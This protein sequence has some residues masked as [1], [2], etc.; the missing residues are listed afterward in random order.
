MALFV[1][2]FGK[3][4]KKK[5]YGVRRRKDSSKYKDQPRR[6]YKWKSKDHLVA[7]CPYNSD[8]D[9]NEKKEKKDK[10]MTFKKKKKGHSYCVTWDS[11]ASSSDDD[12]SDDERKTIKKKALAS[13]AINKPSLF[14][15][16]STCFMAKSNKVQSDD[17]SSDESESEDEEEPSKEEL[18]DMLQEAHSYTNKKRKEFKELRKMHQA[19][20][21][22][23]D[24]LNATHEMIVE[25]H[26]KLEKSHSSLVAQIEKL[27]HYYL[28][29]E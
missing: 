16:P 9:E 12:D 22:S 7:K 17:E 25:A 28:T 6:C 21:Q 3:F 11:D 26:E 18:F 24:E 19:L 1:R 27:I 14:D 20:E 5:G 8:N 23:Y 15:T 4:M 10:K 13:I 2:R 29:Y